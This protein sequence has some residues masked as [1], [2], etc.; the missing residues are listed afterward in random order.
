[1][2]ILKSINGSYTESGGKVMRFFSDSDTPVALG[3]PVIQFTA[4]VCKKDSLLKWN[5]V[6][7]MSAQAINGLFTSALKF[8]IN[9][10]RPFVTYPNDI[11]K[12]GSA[13]SYSFPSGHTSMAF[14][15]AT[16]LSLQYPK[17][18]VIVPAYAWSSTVAFSRMYLGVHYPSDVLGGIILGSGTALLSHYGVRYV[19]RKCNE[20]KVRL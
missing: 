20:R 8:V 17:W 5:G 15:A 3:M 10:P 16:T 19:A 1:V 4:G 18:Y 12:H 2:D 6:E 13:G 14:A 7:N 11:E 9:R